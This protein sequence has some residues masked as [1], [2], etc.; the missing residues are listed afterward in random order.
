MASSS[1]DTESDSYY[2]DDS[3][4]NYIPG[5]YQI[6][7][8][9]ATDENIGEVQSSSDRVQDVGLYINE[10]IADK[11]WLENTARKRLDGTEELSTW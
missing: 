5:P 10:P 4:W 11:E 7:N 1:S 3:E 6:K 8:P 9:S 2:S